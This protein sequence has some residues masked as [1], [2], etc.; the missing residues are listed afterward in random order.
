MPFTK[1]AIPLANRPNV[2]IATGA[3]SPRTVTTLV[4]NDFAP[5]SISL[6][7]LR[8]SVP[9]SMS[10]VI[11]LINSTPRGAKDSCSL[12]IAFSSLNIGDSST[13][14]SSRSDRIANCS[15]DAFESS[16]TL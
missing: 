5:A 7:F 11:I 6:N 3:M 9:N 13:F 2:I 8:M 1:L 16:R 15:A 10:G 14:F 12:S 4:T